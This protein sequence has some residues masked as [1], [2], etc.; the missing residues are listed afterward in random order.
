MNKSRRRRTRQFLVRWIWMR[1]GRKW[2]Y[3]FDEW[4]NDIPF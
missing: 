4:Q 2:G 3:G 1:T